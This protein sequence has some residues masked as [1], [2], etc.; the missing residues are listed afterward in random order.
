M[1]S[2]AA[3]SG[4]LTSTKA[5]LLFVVGVPRSGTT[6]LRELL[7]QHEQIEI[8]LDEMQLLPRLIQ[9]C[10][11]D[12]DFSDEAVVNQVI[13]IL[14]NSNFLYHMDRKC[15]PYDLERLRSR[16]RGQDWPGLADELIREFLPKGKTPR[17]V[18]EKTPSNLMQIER[19]AAVFPDSRFVHIV[20]DPRDVCLSMKNVW[21]KNLYRG[22]VRWLDYIRYYNAVIKRPELAHRCFEFRYED[23]I[24]EPERELR[25]LCEFLGVDFQ[26]SMMSL[27]RGAEKLGAA[28]GAKDIRMA[29]QNK[30]RD[31]L[32]DAE[33][34]M[35]ESVTWPFLE[36]YGYRPL[37]ALRQIRV[38]RLR[39]QL[40]G[41]LDLLNGIRSHVRE[42]GLVQGVRY[43]IRQLFM[44]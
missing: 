18:G 33:I 43:R 10:G 44:K 41:G 21:G 38:N 5:P 7:S 42:K 35:I 28:A 11:V 27:R 19:F 16:L 36:Q 29:N 14:R 37:L 25:R 2:T 8:P 3:S 40:S 1:N 34:K 20:R 23:L 12:A 13:E 15:F 26:V 30:F 22:A 32:R 17:I 24:S 39:Y 6:M 9:V 4:E 31:G